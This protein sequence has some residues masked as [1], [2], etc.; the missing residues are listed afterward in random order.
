MSSGRRRVLAVAGAALV[1]GTLVT[2]LVM[3]TSPRP[4][5]VRQVQGSAAPPTMLSNTY[6]TSVVGVGSA[7]PPPRPPSPTQVAS[8]ETPSPDDRPSTTPS[9]PSSTSLLP[10]WLRELGGC[11][12]DYTTNGVCVPWLFP[13]LVD[14]CEW[15]RTRGSL[16]IEVRGLDRHQLDVN[17]DGIACGPG[18]R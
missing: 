12:D 3:A 17:L 15:L 2:A 16:H 9:R 6:T 18:D 8:P 13:L 5:D 1:G 4:V 7:T 14:P 10:P 11:D